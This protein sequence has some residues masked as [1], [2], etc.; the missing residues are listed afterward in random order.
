M[1]E[2]RFD[3]LDAKPAD[4]V[5]EF[6]ASTEQAIFHLDPISER[7][8]GQRD[9]LS[10]ILGYG[11]R[12]YFSPRYRRRPGGARNRVKS[13]FDPL[14]T[15]PYPND[16]LAGLNG[17]QFD[18][19]ARALRIVLAL[20]DEDRLVNDPED[21]MCVEANGRRTPVERLS[22][23]YKSMFAMVV[24]IIHELLDY[25][26]NLEL[27]Q[28]VV[29][30]DEIETH[31]HPRWKMQIM[32]SLRKALPRVQF[33]VT[34]HDPLCL[35]GMD[36][37]EV[38]VL[39]RVERGKIRALENLPSVKGMT[40]EELLTSDYFGLSSTT[41]PRLELELARLKGDQV[42]RDATGETIVTLS[43]KTEEMLDSLSLGNSAAQ[44]VMQDAL[45]TYLAEREVARGEL[46]S[47]VREEAVEAILKAL[48][49]PI[50]E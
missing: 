38:L 48:S 5:V 32:T 43:T 36:D 23:G 20:N 26:P 40:A 22:E 12:R 47:D 4:A 31:L 46:R 33:I 9:P 25:Y 2:T 35:R 3:Q 45:K 37:D 41:D 6:Y 28:A 44:S 7:I 1:D 19:V 34:T 29:L 17:E 8:T 30:V 15:I 13:L 21:G 16:W 49:A 18:T 24:D 50:P 11:P 14:A 10:V 39:Q 27:A 42:V